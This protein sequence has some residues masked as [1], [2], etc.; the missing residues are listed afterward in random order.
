MSRDVPA[1]L[2]MVPEFEGPCTV[3]VPSVAFCRRPTRLM[4]TFTF[5]FGRQEQTGE[6]F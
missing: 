2:N 3:V 5:P 4:G 6:L 1:A